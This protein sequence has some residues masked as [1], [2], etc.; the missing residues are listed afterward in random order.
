MKKNEKKNEKKM[1]KNY[2]KKIKQLKNPQTVR[3]KN[4]IF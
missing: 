3:R 2:E 1:R 4:R